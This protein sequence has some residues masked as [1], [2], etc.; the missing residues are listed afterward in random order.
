MIVHADWPAADPVLVASDE[1]TVAIQING[2]RR[3]EITLR[4]DAAG[5]EVETAVLAMESIVRALNGARPKK[6][7]VVPNRIVNVVV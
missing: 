3:D 5:A 6:V 1:V 7:I 4:K 2:K